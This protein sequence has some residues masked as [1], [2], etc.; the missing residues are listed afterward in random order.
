[1][2]IIIGMNL[3]F[4]AILNDGELYCVLYLHTGI[5]GSYVALIPMI[6]HPHTAKKHHLNETF[7]EWW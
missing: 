6:S 4:Q 7:R 2:T 3:L 5:N 1:M